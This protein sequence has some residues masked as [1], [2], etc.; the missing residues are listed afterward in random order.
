MGNRFRWD[1]ALGVV[2]LVDALRVFLPSLITLFGQAGSTPAE[3]MALFALVWFLVPVAVVPLLRLV[4]AARIMPVALGI[5][6]AGRIVLQATDGGAFQLY[7]S[8]VAVAAGLTWLTAVAA[9][10][11][12][13][14]TGIAGFL[15]GLWIA[16]IVHISLDGVDLMWRDPLLAW[17]LL[18]VEL[19]ALGVAVRRRPEPAE[20]EGS[21]L[22]WLGCGPALLLWGMVFGNPAHTGMSMDSG[23]VWLAGVV[24]AAAA[25]WWLLRLG[26]ATSSRIRNLAALMLA[27]AVLVFLF[28]A[29]D[30]ARAPVIALGL[31]WTTGIA[32]VALLCR[33]TVG[34]GTP[35]GRAI[36]FAVSMLGFLVLTFGYYGA[37]DLYLVNWWVP[38]VAAAAVAAVGLVPSAPDPRRPMTLQFAPRTAAVV[39]A[40]LALAGVAP[41]WQSVSPS[42]DPPQDGLRVAAYNIRMGYGLDGRLSLDA[43]ADALAALDPHVIALSEV[44]RGWFLNGGHDDLRHIA[45]RLGMEFVWAPAA[46][47]HWGDAVLTNLPVV[48]TVSHPLVAGGPTGAQAL[49]V[50]VRW[51]GEEVTVI[52]T[53]L[54]PPP[55]WRPL[56]QVEQLAGIAAEAAGGG[57]VV[58][59]GDLNLEP[60]SAA[61][62][63]LTDAGLHD[64]F[65]ESRP[66]YSIPG[67]ST[68]QIDH[69]LVTADWTATDPANPDVPHSDHRPIAVTLTL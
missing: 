4:P 12:D 8:A 34:R 55:D 31:A 32:V 65:A 51:R 46:D 23:L 42:S 67:D 3:Y 54:Q 49:E 60:G 6:V 41:L 27:G 59:A 29:P 57:P 24:S 28:P 16:T 17:P 37:Y 35:R 61:W 18:A 33:P 45:D 36:A 25:L 7:V 68:E 22:P 56:D 9:D 40:V 15:G 20:G 39:G 63:V 30:P 38:V 44:D 19:L 2:V 58:L 11:R 26:V 53:H 66:L 21:A 64:A 47:Q 5:L 13:S 62:D 52:A 48:R 50:A 69:V 10:R 14:H 1:V 43:Q